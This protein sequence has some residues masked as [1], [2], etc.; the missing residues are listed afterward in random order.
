MRA[1]SA[2]D[3]LAAPVDATAEANK[4]IAA[5]SIAARIAAIDRSLAPRRWDYQGLSTSHQRCLGSRRAALFP[6]LRGAYFDLH[7]FRTE[8]G[9]PP[10]SQPG[11][12]RSAASTIFGPEDLVERAAE[13]RCVSASA[14]G[15]GVLLGRA[16]HS[17]V[18]SHPRAQGFL[19]GKETEA[20]RPGPQQASL[21]AGSCWTQPVEWLSCGSLLLSLP[22]LRWSRSQANQQH[23]SCSPVLASYRLHSL[24]PLTIRRRHA[25]GCGERRVTLDE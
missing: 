2:P 25:R 14:C 1:G 13:G 16:R 20:G 9:S 4:A 3:D 17:P 24:Q 5:T 12:H 7:N 10:N 22:V 15:R 6:L 23:L 19:S 18:G 11:S 8:S 21:S